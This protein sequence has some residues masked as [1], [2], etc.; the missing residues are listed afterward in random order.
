MAMGWRDKFN[1]AVNVGDPGRA[2]RVIRDARRATVHPERPWWRPLCG[3]DPL[4]L[5]TTSD[6]TGMLFAPW[7]RH[8]G[9]IADVPVTESTTW[10]Q[11]CV[12]LSDL[13]EAFD[14][15]NPVIHGPEN[16]D[17]ETRWLISGAFD[18]SDL[19]VTS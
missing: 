12:T 17:A 19:E 4:D 14:R 10:E 2:Q 18:V 1:D 5:R 7:I 11:E 13:V 16:A 6:E 9:A 3:E 15:L 8:D